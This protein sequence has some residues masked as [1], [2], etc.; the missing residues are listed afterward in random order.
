MRAFVDTATSLP[1]I[2]GMVLT[3]V[4]DQ[5]RHALEVVEDLPTAPRAFLFH[6]PSV[7]QTSSSHALY[8][9]E[10]LRLGRF[11]EWVGGHPPRAE[12][13]VSTLDTFDRRRSGLRDSCGPDAAQRLADYYGSNWVPPVR[14]GPA[15]NVIPVALLGGSLNREDFKIHDLVE[16]AGGHIMVDGTEGALRTLPAPFDRRRLWDAPLDELVAAY[17]GTIPDV[18]RR[19][20]SGLFQ[21]IAGHLGSNDIKGVILMRQVWCDKWH[22]EVHRIRALL[23]LPLL[24]IDLDGQPCDARTQTRIQAFMESLR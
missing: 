6:L 12:E 21:W 10:L 24:D 20:N 19:P 18:F 14:P 5:M 1:G 4:C 8:R 22:A 7:W 13:L 23:K 3:T 11:L 2:R 15:A 17:F 9:S 16:Q